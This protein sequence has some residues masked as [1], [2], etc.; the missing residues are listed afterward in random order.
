MYSRESASGIK[1]DDGRSRASPLTK[2]GVQKAGPGGEVQSRQR[3][4]TNIGDHFTGE[5]REVARQMLDDSVKF[6]NE[7]S[8]RILN[9]YNEVRT[10]S[11][12]SAKECWDSSPTTSAQSS[13][14]SVRP[15]RP[16]TARTQKGPRHLRFLGDT[17][18]LTCHARDASGQLFGLC[19]IEP[20]LEFTLTEIRGPQVDVRGA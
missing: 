18:R 19:E 20:R 14:C 12:T 16:V 2:N 13:A 11:E 1:R 4:R 8:S 10:R 3:I 15:D 7:T 17:A 9:H 6:L 5:A